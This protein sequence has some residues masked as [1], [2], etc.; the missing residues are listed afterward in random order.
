MVGGDPRTHRQ[1]RNLYYA[2]D[3][4]P[5]QE[6]ID[7]GEEEADNC[8]TLDHVVVGT[9]WHCY[10]ATVAVVLYASFFVT[11]KGAGFVGRKDQVRSLSEVVVGVDHSSY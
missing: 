7:S 3:R 6:R 10:C 5:Q 8:S 9:E 11:W 2:H 4:E 1:R